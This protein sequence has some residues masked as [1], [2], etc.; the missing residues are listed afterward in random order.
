MER[1]VIINGRPTVVLFRT[2]RDKH[3]K[4][5][6]VVHARKISKPFEVHTLEG[7]MKGKRGDWLIRGVEGELYPC[8]NRIFKK[9]YERVRIPEAE[10]PKVGKEKIKTYIPLDRTERMLKWLIICQLV[11]HP[12]GQILGNCSYEEMLEIMPNISDIIGKNK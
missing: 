1:K 2:V 11:N 7:I 10:A 3:R 6:V 9:T 8:D 12:T 4:K 5:P